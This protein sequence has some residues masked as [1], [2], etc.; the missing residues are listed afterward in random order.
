MLVTLSG[1]VMLVSPVQPENAE[2]P[3]LVTLFGIV[4]FVSSGHPQKAESPMLVTLPSAGITLVLHPA[5]KVFV[6]VSVCKVRAV[7]ECLF[8][9]ICDAVRQNNFFYVFQTGKGTF[10]DSDNGIAAQ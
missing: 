3:M 8:A 7:L 5:I 6:A 10:A 2:S 9:D 4:T 1:I